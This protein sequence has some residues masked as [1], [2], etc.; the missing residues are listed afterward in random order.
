MSFCLNS[1]TD[2]EV[3][4]HEIEKWKKYLA[5]WKH[6]M[7][8]WKKECRRMTQILSPGFTWNSLPTPC[9][10]ISRS[11]STPVTPCPFSFMLS[12]DPV[13]DATNNPGLSPLHFSPSSL[14][15]HVFISNWNYLNFSRF[16][17]E[18]NTIS[19]EVLIA[20]SSISLFMFSGVDNELNWEMKCI[21][22]RDAFKCITFLC[23]GAQCLQSKSPPNWGHV[24]FR[25]TSLSVNNI[26]SIFI[27]WF[28]L[29][30]HPNNIFPRLI[31]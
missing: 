11:P 26:I 28:N 6:K 17:T 20:S 25:I 1:W 30:L 2:V 21:T 12:C 3:N 24:V 18:V 22:G 27:F 7:R 9:L 31:S 10:S 23:T 29:K 16:E 14:L 8:K 19:V 15:F 5:T 13:T 4:G